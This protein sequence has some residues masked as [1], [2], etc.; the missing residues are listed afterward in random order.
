VEIRLAVAGDH[1]RLAECSCA[2]PQFRH[3]TKRVQQIIRGPLREALADQTRAVTA[4]LA[5]DDAETLVGVAAIEPASDDP[6]VWAVHVLAVNQNSRGR[7][8]G[9]RLFES[10]LAMCRQHGAT[11]AVIEVHRANSKAIRFFGHFNVVW[12]ELPD[13]E[14]RQ[15]SIKLVD[16]Q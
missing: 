9:S 5:L 3:G 2:G 12:S 7:S 4:L 6:E 16:F 14:Y 10:V 8:V 15:G 1:V 13:P 11:S